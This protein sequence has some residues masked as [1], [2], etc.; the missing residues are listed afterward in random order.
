MDS[1]ESF[2]IFNSS[3]GIDEEPEEEQ[4]EQVIP[5]SPVQFWTFLIFEIPSLACTIFLLYHLLFNRQLRNALHNHVIII[6]LFLTLFIEI[7]DN[8]LYIDAYR[9]GGNQN[10]FPITSSICLMWWFIDYGFYGAI[11]VFLAWGSIERHI[12][13]FHSRQL[14]RTQRQRFFIHYLPLIIISIYLLGF[15][16]GV[17]FFPPCENIFDFESLACGLSPCYE[18]ISY[19]N[20]WDYLGNGIICAFIETIFSMAL[21]I[22]ILWQKHRAR[23]RVNWRKHRKMA[24]QLLPVSCLSLT[25]VFPLSLLAVIQQIGGPSMTN[26]GA[27]VQPY[28]FY[29]YTFVVFL[30]PFICLVNLPELWPKLLF[31][32]PKRQQTAGVITLMVDR[33]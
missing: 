5:P 19:L 27:A 15:Y 1:N 31:F 9:F 4:P 32:K 13:V 22:R 33:C 3:T 14:L 23:Q 24:F 2:I 21:L 17:I 6:F 7:L 30:L 20:I 29:L 8:P 10:S 12:L 28:L 25:I 18:E 26:F 11:T 16:I